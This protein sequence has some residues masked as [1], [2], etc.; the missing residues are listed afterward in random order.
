MQT[1]MTFYLYENG[2]KGRLPEIGIRTMSAM[3]SLCMQFNAL[4]GVLPE[5]G[6]QA[7][8]T[9]RDLFVYA[10]HFAGTLP[11]RAVAGLSML[12]AQENDFEGEHRH[13]MSQAQYFSFE[14]P[15]NTYVVQRQESA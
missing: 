10:N 6:L 8:R 11:N 2:F 1:V 14:L 4:T 12:V 5:S 7:M 9:M 3:E 15:H 13:K